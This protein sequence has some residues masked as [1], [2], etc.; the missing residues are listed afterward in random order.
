[1]STG[2]YSV[3]WT[4]TA[5][6]QLKKFDKPVAKAILEGTKALGENDPTLDIIKLEGF[7]NLY[8]LRL[9]NYR[10]IFR[11]NHTDKK[12]FIAEVAHRKDVYRSLSVSNLPEA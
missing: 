1:M 8:R 6:K 10:V 9:G 4:K 2:K 12:Y 7:E 11:P 5:A 3:I